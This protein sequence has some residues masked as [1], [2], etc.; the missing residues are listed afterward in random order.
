MKNNKSLALI[1]SGALVLPLTGCVSTSSQITKPEVSFGVK[2]KAFSKQVDTFVELGGLNVDLPSFTNIPKKEKQTTTLVEEV[3]DVTYTLHTIDGEVARVDVSVSAED[4]VDELEIDAGFN[5][6]YSYTAMAYTLQPSLF[7]EEDS[8]EDF[9]EFYMDFMEEVEGLEEDEETGY[10]TFELY[11]TSFELEFI[12]FDTLTFSIVALDEDPYEGEGVDYLSQLGN[13]SDFSN[14]VGDLLG[15]MDYDTD[16]NSNQTNLDEEKNEISFKEETEEEVIEEDET[17]DE[18]VY[19]I[20]TPNDS[21]QS[22]SNSNSSLELPKT[23][24]ASNPAELG[25]VVAVKNKNYKTEQIQDVL[26]TLTNV[27]RGA[28][29]QADLDHFNKTNGYREYDTSD[30]DFDTMELITYTYQV[31]APITD[32]EGSYYG[33]IFSDITNSN[34]DDYIISGNYKHFIMTEDISLD[35]D[36]LEPGKTVEYTRIAAVP[37]DADDLVL[38]LYSL[39]A[40]DEGGFFR[41]K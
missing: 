23:T 39:S 20:T 7:V 29:A 21:N 13:L 33:S 36:S 27:N 19:I 38:K 25:Q 17:E 9:L 14:L 2:P 40:E 30:I 8:V 35:S 41:L 18:P 4:G 32:V 15:D 3:D 22:Q 28:A 5:L 1:L 16:S 11:N 6:G 31:T 26:V 37:K 10:E 34:E 12:P 24:T